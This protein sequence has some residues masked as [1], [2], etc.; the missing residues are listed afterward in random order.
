M[1]CL[2]LLFH[3]CDTNHRGQFETALRLLPFESQTRII[4]KKFS[5]DAQTALANQLLQRYICCCLT[6]KTIRDLQ[7]TTN[8]YGKPRLV[9]SDV[10]FSMSN[11]RGYTSMVVSLIGIE[12][13]VDL[14]STDDVNQFGDDD[15]I[16][17]FRD[18]FHPKEF[19]YLESIKDERTRRDVFTHFWALKE[20]Y[21]KLLGVGLNGDL[22]SYWFSNVEPLYYTEQADENSE[23]LIIHSRI[24]W[25]NQISLRV[26]DNLEKTSIFSTMIDNQV[27][28][29]ICQDAP[30]HDTSPLLIEVPLKTIMDFFQ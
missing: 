17:H 9:D 23:G 3:I 20:S 10:A 1:I 21:T 12:V 29:S 14:A 8:E 7:F 13:G 27:V 5:K 22:T 26:F 11:Q 15:Y 16:K 24:K 18:I 19:E 30:T 28:V 2:S 4:S 25:D 6:G